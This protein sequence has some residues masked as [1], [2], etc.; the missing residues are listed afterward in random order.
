MSQQIFDKRE[1]KADAVR[2]ARR[3]EPPATLTVLGRLPQN[4]S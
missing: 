4:E 1:G 3:R 2:A